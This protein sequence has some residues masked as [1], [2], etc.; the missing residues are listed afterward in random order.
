MTTHSSSPYLATGHATLGEAPAVTARR[1]LAGHGL[2][3]ALLVAAAIVASAGWLAQAASAQPAEGPGPID[4]DGD[5]IDGDLE[6]RFERL[7]AAKEVDVL[8]TLRRS[9]SPQRVAS[10]RR[11]VRGIGVHRRFSVIDAVVASV[12]RA[13]ARALAALP[14]VARIER[15]APVRVANGSA[16]ESFGVAQARAQWPLAEGDGDGDPGTYS[17]RDLVSA[18]ID[19]GID[20]THPDL[21]DGKVLASVNC[22]SGTCTEP[23]VHRDEHGHGSHVAGTLA[24]DGEGEGRY[25]GVAPGAGLV[26]VTALGPTG[27]GTASAAIAGIEW[28]VEHADELGIEA[29]NLSLAGEGCSDGEDAQSKAVDAAVDEGLVVV[30]AA[31]NA[32]PGTCTIA[33]PAAAEKALTVANMA[34]LGVG[35]FFLFSTSSRGPTADGRVKPDVAGP[36]LHIT[37]AEANT[38]LYRDLT[39]TSM[40]TPFV[41]GL[42]LLML[43]V[44]PSL[45]PGQVKQKVMDTAVDWGSGGDGSTPGASGRDIDYGAGR[46]DAHAA[47]RSAGAEGLS[48]PPAVPVHRHYAGKIAGEGDQVEYRLEV[49]GIEAVAATLIVPG[50]EPSGGGPNLDLE[51][52]DPTGTVVASARSGLRQGDLSHRPEHRGTY[53]LTVSGDRGQGDF[54]LDVSAPLDVT[55]PDTSILSGPPATTLARSARFALSASEPDSRF[56]CRLDGRPFKLCSSVFTLSRLSVGRHRLLARALD[57]AGNADRTPATR[58]WHVTPARNRSGSCSGLRGRRRAACVRRHCGRDRGAARRRCIRAVTRRV[59]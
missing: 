56:E 29:I 28:V 31:G 12:T 25:V 6:G 59:R 54:F 8:V 13:Q 34:D 22:V 18:V 17:P 45:S 49:D 5:G 33:S 58:T 19:T 2:L 3:A 26:D 4:R 48:S 21:D 44:A 55:A 36:G 53:T 43:D 35:G 10:L 57:R 37:S 1:R 47:L 9:A 23:P 7:P 52:R 27:E 30:A 41:T 32:G 11:R 40:A 38:G 51:L 14:E 24:G 16:R 15:D 46:L 20:Q 42:G 50:A 39:G